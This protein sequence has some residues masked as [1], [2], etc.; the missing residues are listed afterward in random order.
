MT[1]KKVI[2]TRGRKKY[3]AAAIPLIL[4]AQAQGVEFHVGDVEMS[5][6]TQLTIGSSWRTEDRSDSL[7]QGISGSVTGGQNDND[8]NANFD[9]GDAFSQ[10]FKGTHD[11][12]ISYQNFGAFVRGKY[13]YDTLL[14]DGNKAT[15]S[16]PS[17][18]PISKADGGAFNDDGAS[19]YAKFS[20]AQILDA[21]VYGEFEVGGMPLDV[22]LGKQ[23]L[24]WGES[25]FIQGGIN[26]TNPFDVAAL[27][28]PGAELKEGLIPV[29]M[30]FTSIGLTENLSAEAFYQL[31][32]QE[33]VISLCG[34]FFATNDYAPEGCGPVETPA[35]TISRDVQFKDGIKRPSDDGQFGLAFRYFSE[36]L[37][38]EFGFFALNVHSRV[39]LVSGRKSDLDYLGALTGSDA[40]AAAVYAG[41]KNKFAL[42]NLII[43]GAN[44]A[45]ANAGQADVADWA[46]IE[47]LNAQNDTSPNTA[48]AVAASIHDSFSTTVF[49]SSLTGMT[50]DTGAVASGGYITPMSYYIDY[51]EDQ[52][53]AG[54]SFA[55]NIGGVAVS[56]ELTHKL[57]VP[58]QINSQQLLSTGLT[59]EVTYNLNFVGALGQGAN[60][61]QADA[62]G[63]AA[64]EAS[65]GSFGLEA[66]DLADGAVLDGYKMFD[67]TQAQVT[68]IKLFDQVLGA[69]R[70]ALVAEAGYTYVHEFD[71]DSDIKFSGDGSQNDTVTEGSWGYR[72]RI[73]GDYSDVFAGVSL[74]PV[75]S[76]SHDVEGVAPNPGG[77]FTEDQK[78]IGLA[79]NAEYANMYTASIGYTMYEG[80][81]TNDL[82]D[83]DN[84]SITLGVQF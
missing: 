7:M 8:G 62:A 19:D 46:E 21:F 63:R 47:T 12:Q 20:G 11:F 3:L 51:P 37:D 15:F 73:S 61:A 17:L 22:R 30:L 45:M 2:Q 67:V 56:G 70:Y 79:L 77:N 24:S 29:N 80:G 52:Q 83:R 60:A 75:L 18:D 34:T 53:I 84:A 1:S 23:V 65:L 25:T 38:T 59:T 68:A 57:D 27:R 6:D 26:Q 14:E 31:E 13:W 74:A 35:G 55:T 44:Q 43:A 10:V 66:L 82:E 39:P 5:L 72:L 54:L 4:A 42:D 40:T 33:T 16:D 81:L 50:T 48:T 78:V 28:R 36:E 49:S 9:K 71:E 32:H 41:A 69:N 76:F 58:F 64:V